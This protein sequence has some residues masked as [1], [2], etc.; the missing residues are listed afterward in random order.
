MTSTFS[1]HSRSQPSQVAIADS[2]SSQMM[3]WTDELERIMTAVEARRDQRAASLEEAVGGLP[4][5]E[6][7]S[8]K[9]AERQPCN[10]ET[11]GGPLTSKDISELALL[12]AEITC[13]DVSF[14]RG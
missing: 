7:T 14:Q 13:S 12:R 2:S 9:Y 3:K 4:M 1:N 8:D 5:L 11:L 6:T 10:E